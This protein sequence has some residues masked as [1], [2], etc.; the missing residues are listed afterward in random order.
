[1]FCSHVAGS[2]KKPMK[3]AMR[4]PSAPDALQQQPDCHDVRPH[5]SDK[6]NAQVAEKVSADFYMVMQSF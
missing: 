1:M 5:S 3:H 6:E 4:H 2:G